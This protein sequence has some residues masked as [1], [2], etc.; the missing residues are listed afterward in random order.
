SPSGP[1]VPM[2]VVFRPA[3]MHRQGQR[4]TGSPPATT[5]RNDER[6]SWIRNHPAPPER[7]QGTGVGVGGGILDGA[8]VGG[9]GGGPRKLKGRTSPRGSLGGAGPSNET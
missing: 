9:G 7:G 4:P 5:N 2:F 6:S 1:G 8:P 3:R